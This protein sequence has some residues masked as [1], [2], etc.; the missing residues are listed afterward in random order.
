MVSEAISS[1]YSGINT[2]ATNFMQCID[3]GPRIVYT[4]LDM[5]LPTTTGR[6][7]TTTTQRPISGKI[8]GVNKM[9]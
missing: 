4:P 9:T 1:M 5:E 6:T 3:K 2:A 7:T 8:I